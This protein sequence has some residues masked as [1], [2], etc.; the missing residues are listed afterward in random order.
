MDKNLNP[1]LINECDEDILVVQKEI[2]NHKV[3]LINAYG[4][5]EGELL[6][7]RISFFEKLDEEIQLSKLIY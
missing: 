1:M 5:Q 3:R 4:P 6:H 2:G 7:K